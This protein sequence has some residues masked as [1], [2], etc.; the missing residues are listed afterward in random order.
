MSSANYPDNV[1]QPV[2]YNTGKI[3]CIDAIEESMSTEEFCG[4]LKGNAEKYLWRYRYKGKPIE[5]LE[6]CRWYLE[7]LIEVCKHD[8]STK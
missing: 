4:Y 3:E 6:K 5:D 8:Q 7:R 1:H 2:H